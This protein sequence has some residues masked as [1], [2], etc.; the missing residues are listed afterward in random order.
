MSGRGFPPPAGRPVTM[1]PRPDPWVEQARRDA[2]N[3]ALRR[4]RRRRWLAPI[5]AVLVL[6]AVA[7]V[8]ALVAAFWA[9]GGGG[10]AGDVASDEGSAN[11]S[12]LTTVASPGESIPTVSPEDLVAVDEVWLVD[13]GD[14]VFDWGV[15]VKTQPSA[16]ARRDVAVTVRLLAADGEIVLSSTDSLGVIDAD[17]PAA[18][19][20]RLVDPQESPVRIEF[21]VSVGEPSDSAAL[22]D[23]LDVRAL[24][25]DGDEM[26]GR[27]RSLASTDIGDLRVLFVWRDEDGAVVATAPLSIDVLRPNIDARFSVDLSE[28][29]VPDG[30]PDSV[31]WVR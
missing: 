14:G 30:R 19:A 4:R 8:F 15:A 3:R 27:I 16:P 26:T 10:G 22:A 23:L 25:R 6:A 2:A 9:D 28:E 18:V 12:T 20:G 1:F 13:R 17:S 29:V 11:V 7:G 24:E 21:D 5:A 31:F